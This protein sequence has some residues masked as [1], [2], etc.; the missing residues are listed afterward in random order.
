[1]LCLTHHERLSGLGDPGRPA[2]SPD[3][4]IADH[5]VRFAGEV[6]VA[7]VEFG[8]QID[9]QVFERNQLLVL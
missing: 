5:R 2:R 4:P 3:R 8:F 6:A 9:F 1:L 7:L